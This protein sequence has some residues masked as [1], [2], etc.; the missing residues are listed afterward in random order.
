MVI[1]VA[2]GRIIEIPVGIRADLDA[3]ERNLGARID[4]AVA[5]CS[6]EGI[7]IIDFQ[8]LV[9]STR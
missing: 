9:L 7:Y 8:V 4:I 2:C 3:S 6:H 1:F 5:G